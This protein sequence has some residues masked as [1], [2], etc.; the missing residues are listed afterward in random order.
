[1]SSDDDFLE[2]LERC[3]K[4]ANPPDDGPKLTFNAELEW[5]SEWVGFATFAA[6]LDRQG[7]AVRI[8]VLARELEISWQNLE[9]KRMRNLPTEEAQAIRDAQTIFLQQLVGELK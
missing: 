5:L 7:P 6:Y 2:Y 3:R 1:M 8:A 4:H 9:W